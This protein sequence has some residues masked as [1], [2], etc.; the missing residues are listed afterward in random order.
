M[1]PEI[2]IPMRGYEGF[3]RAAGSAEVVLDVGR[4]GDGE[5]RIRL[6]AAVGGRDCA[7]IGSVS[8][9]AD[10]LLALLLSAETLKAHGAH[11][12][13]AVLPYLAYARSDIP[14]PG[15]VQSIGVIGRALARAGFDR[16]VTVDVHSPAAALLVPIPLTS[17]SPA[18]ILGA[19]LCNEF[20]FDAVI[21]PDRGAFPRA[22]ALADALGLDDPLSASQV[23]GTR[24]ALVVDDIIDTGATL[25]RCCDVLVDRGVEEIVVAVT[26]GVF[27]DP[28]WHNLLKL[29]PVRALYTTDTI[30]EVERQHR[31]LTR[32]VSVKPLI[33]AALSDGVTAGARSG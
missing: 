9:P 10:S 5:L 23:S 33:D 19:E 13:T 32:I 31:Y 1:K 14:D 25:S 8:P 29:R 17:L 12:V 4:F 27:T 20:D 28:E 30:P 21:A 3:A 2:V 15:S 22:R 6:R 18:G 26:H 11:R 24:S 7:L 16:I